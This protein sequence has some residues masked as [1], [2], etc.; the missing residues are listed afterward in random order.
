MSPLGEVFEI[1][2]LDRFEQVVQVL[3][4]IF[5]VGRTASFIGE[6][7]ISNQDGDARAEEHR[8]D[9]VALVLVAGDWQESTATGVEMS[10]N[11]ALESF[12]EHVRDRDDLSSVVKVLHVETLA[13][14]RDRT[15]W[16]IE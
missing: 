1:L 10:H 4:R 6:P 7:R 3:E 2:V 16:A 15:G 5:V 9:D 12:G 14:G 11:D 13:L 8:H